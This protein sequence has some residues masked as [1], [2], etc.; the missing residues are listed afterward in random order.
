MTLKSYEDL[1]ENLRKVFDKTT[2]PYYP[3]TISPPP[4]HLG[5]LES[6]AGALDFYKRQGVT[7]VCIQPKYMG[8]RCIIQL[9]RES[10]GQ[11][12]SR[13]GY[14]IR[15][16]G[17]DELLEQLSIKF[18]SLVEHH[19]SILLD[20]ELLPWVALADGHN[21]L[22]FKAASKCLA[23]ECQLLRDFDF[24][25]L[26]DIRHH[27]DVFIEQVEHFSKPGPLEYKPFELLKIGE[28]VVD[29]AP[30]VNFAKVSDDQA[31][32]ID[33]DDVD[34]AEQFFDLLTEQNM[35]GVVIKP[36]HEG[37][38]SALEQVLPALKVRNSK[39]LTMVY[40][41]HYLEYLD[42]LVAKKSIGSKCKMSKQQ[43]KLGKAMLSADSEQFAK[44]KA[45]FLKLDI[46]NKYIDWKL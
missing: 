27:A 23:R 26:I 39:Y 5:Q 2:S 8:S 34:K 3:Y 9:D 19:G 16:A 46:K 42:R 29:D 24:D 43:A 10:Q 22:T 1:D 37:Y 36:E 13:S 4:V 35:E 41:P 31:L 32:T 14:R 21:N 18:A 38:T 44:L 12:W 33:I 15:I 11:A 28:T 20:G 7:R 30:S 6:I 17:I 40:G 25:G 45:T